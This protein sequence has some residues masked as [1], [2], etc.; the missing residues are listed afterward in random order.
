MAD[1]VLKSIKFPGL[2]NRYTVPPVDN[3]LTQ[4]GRPADAKKTG[5][6]IA[7]IR[8]NAPFSVVDGMLCVSYDAE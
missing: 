6:E 5:D 3:T 7:D 8:E 2:P 4:A 1:V